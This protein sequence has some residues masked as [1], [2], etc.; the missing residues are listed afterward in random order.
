MT[1]MNYYVISNAFKPASN[2]PSLKMLIFMVLFLASIGGLLT[3]G[4][5][6]SVITLME[7]IYFAILQCFKPKADQPQ[8]PKHKIFYVQPLQPINRLSE[9]NL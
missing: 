9:A 3:L 5:G 8:R 7:F 6:F 2:Q 4:F 1:K